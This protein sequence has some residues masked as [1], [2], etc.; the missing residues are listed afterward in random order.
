MAAITTAADLGVPETFNAAAHFVDRHPSEGRG[1]KVAIECGDERVTYAQ[2]A[3][4][5]N[6]FGSALRD[7]LDVRPEERVVLLLLDTPAFASRS[8]ARS[9]SARC[10]FPPTRCGSRPTTATSSTTRAR[11]S[12]SS[13]R[14]CCRRSRAI[15][16]ADVPA[17]RHVVVG[18]ARAGGRRSFAELLER[19]SPELEAEPTSRD[20][21]AFWLY[22]SGSTGAPK[23]CVHLHHDMVVCAELF[24]QGRARH[25]RERDRCFS[26]AKLFFAYGLGNAL[27]L[28]ARRRR[29][30]HP[31]AGPA[32]AARTSTRSIERHRPTLFFSVPTGYA[33]AARAAAGRLRSVVGPARRVG[34]RGA[35][36]RRSTSA[37]SSG[38]ASTSSTASA[39]PKCCTCSSR[40]APARS[41]PGSSG[42]IVP[43]YDAAILDEDKRPVPPGEIG[44]LWISGDST[45][46]AYWNQHEKTKATI[47]GD[48][49]RTG[50]RYTQDAD[51]FY[52]YGGRSDDMLKVGG[53]WVSPIEVENALAR[54]RRGAGMRRGRPRGS[55]HA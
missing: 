16:R 54:A 23:G 15:D 18:G 49:I 2:L 7:E 4:R 28:S 52:W 50:D 43:G 48:W 27:L 26:V 10:R 51:G 3:E 35:A 41:G 14:S 55:R 1:A 25:R 45:C 38:S 46:A 24:A 32:D 6:R 13:A 17:L 44:N 31:D 29:D 53:L 36:G 19:G 30:Q 12:R 22:S 33:H 9:R 21:P 11:A 20:A 37:S 5:V 42:L 34:G 39:R 47:E 40:T 8:S